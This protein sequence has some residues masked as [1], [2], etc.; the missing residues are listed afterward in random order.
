MHQ[1]YILFRC[2]VCP[3]NVSITEALAFYVSVAIE[4]LMVFCDLQENLA[5]TK[6]IVNLFNKAALQFSIR[7][8]TRQLYKNILKFN[9]LK[10]GDTYIHHRTESSL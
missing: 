6:G 2:A 7:P 8:R 9:L 3:V 1:S 4:N 5:F 10:P